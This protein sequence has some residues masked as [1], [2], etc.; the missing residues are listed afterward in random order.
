MPIYDSDNRPP[1]FIDEFNELIR[2]RS[3]LIELISR[4]IKARYKR[5]VLG[6]AWTMLHPLMTMA[7]LAFVFSQVFRFS[8]QNYPVYLLSGLL[9][10]NLFTTTTTHAMAQLVWGGGLL[11]RIYIPKAV[12]AVSSVGTG[13]VNIFIALVPLM[14]IMLATGV[15]FSVSLLTLPVAIFLTALFSLGVGLVLSALAVYFAD[16]LRIYEIILTMWMYATPIFYPLDILP[17]RFRW[18]VT[19]N[20]MYYLVDLFRA[21]VTQGVIAPLSSYIYA[22]LAV[23]ISLLIG[24]WVFSRETGEFAYRI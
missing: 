20:P 2:Y 19:L 24:W 4:D 15:P 14:I 13:L 5:S 11:N 6:V 23:T 17:E 12:F 21:P 3:L 9:I 16:V 22:F 10:W 18:I 8:I 1:P 7:I